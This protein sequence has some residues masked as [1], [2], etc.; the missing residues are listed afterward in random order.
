[1]KTRDLPVVLLLSALLLPGAAVAAEEENPQASEDNPQAIRECLRK[2]GRH[3][4][5]GENPSYKELGGGVKVLG[6][7]KR[8][9]DTEVTTAPRLVL[10]DPA[11]SVLTK[12]TYRLLNPNGWYCL[13]DSV[14]VLGKSVIE[15][16]CRARL[17]ASSKSVTVLG[18][19][20]TE[21]TT[22]LGK[23]VVKR[24]GCG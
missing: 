5:K 9:E 21:G 12:N 3:P 14:T 15:A 23:A 22:V 8:V 1:M 13:K 2:W 24:V 16:H 19:G 18:S 17:T 20:G 7:G 11:V 10:V 6:I 4:F